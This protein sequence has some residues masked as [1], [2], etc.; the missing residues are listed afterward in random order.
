MLEE[1][2]PPRS[3][4]CIKGQGE[5]KCVTLILTLAAR[6]TLAELVGR[7]PQIR[8]CPVCELPIV[9]F[10]RI[11]LWDGLQSG[12]E[13][14]RLSAKVTYGP[15]KSYGTLFLMA[16]VPHILWG[17]L[18]HLLLLLL[19]EKH[20]HLNIGSERNPCRI[21]GKATSDQTLPSL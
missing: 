4:S 11:P 9:N 12:G 2:R 21:G 13:R 17:D 18:K 1:T 20:P 6:G 10:F 8:L 3:S 15:A 14:S 5:G 16:R 7:R 19:L